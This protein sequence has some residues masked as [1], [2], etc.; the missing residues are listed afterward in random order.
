MNYK[1]LLA[2]FGICLKHYKQRQPDA[3]PF[4]D[5]STSTAVHYRAFLVFRLEDRLT[6]GTSTTTPSSDGSVAAD[7]SGD[8]GVAAAA[9]FDRVF[10][11]EVG[12]VVV[13]AEVAG[14]ARCLTGEEGA[15]VEG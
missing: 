12:A 13:A 4:Q 11:A 15:G 1:R 6:V 5:V 2:L 8:S 10:L 3:A 7:G 9:V 14:V